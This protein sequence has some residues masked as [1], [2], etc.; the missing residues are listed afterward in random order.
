MKKSY[1]APQ[2]Q[3]LTLQIEGMIAYS[4]DKNNAIEVTSD[5]QHTQGL[6]QES[7]WSEE[8]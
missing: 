3:A 8:E 7:I 6:H 1:I 2:A 5:T 4:I